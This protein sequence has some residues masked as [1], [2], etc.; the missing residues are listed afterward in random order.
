MVVEELDQVL[1]DAD[2]FNKLDELLKKTG[3]DG[4]PLF[5]RIIISERTRKLE[6]KWG[7]WGMGVPLI[8][9]SSPYRSLLGPLTEYID[10]LQRLGPNQR[11]LLDLV[12]SPPNQA[13]APKVDVQDAIKVP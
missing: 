2:L 4:T 1:Q 12:D 3:G 9:L 6:E 7:K 11:L 5:D 8:V 13:D 10:T